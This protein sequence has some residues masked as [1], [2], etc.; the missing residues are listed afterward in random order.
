MAQVAY[1]AKNNVFFVVNGDKIHGYWSS[2]ATCG[3]NKEAKPSLLL[4]I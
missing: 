1:K 3:I 4:K 2:W